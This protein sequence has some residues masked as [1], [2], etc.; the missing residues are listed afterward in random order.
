MRT[1]K[2][3][4]WDLLREEMYGKGHGMS[5]SV[6][7]EYDDSVE[8]H[9][10]HE[11]SD[12]NRGPEKD[13]HGIPLRQLMQFTGLHD[14]DGREIYESD[15]VRNSYKFAQPHVCQVFIE[16]GN[17]YLSGEDISTGGDMLLCDFADQCEVIGNIYENPEVLE[18]SK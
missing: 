6:R 4:E 14:K 9:F 1:I 10:A 15:I 17:T 5:Y 11:E 18:A 8:F 3:R 12:D 16:C 13:I 2:F 7:V